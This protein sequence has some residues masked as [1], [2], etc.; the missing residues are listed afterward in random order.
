MS[1]RDKPIAIATM[2][3]GMKSFNAQFIVLDEVGVTKARDGHT[4]HHYLVAD[5]TAAI[6]LSLWDAVGEAVRL[7][8]ILRLNNGYC[9]LHNQFLHLYTAKGGRLIRIGQFSM[10]FTETPNLSL[11][12]WADPVP[13]EQPV[14]P[15]PFFFFDLALVM[16]IH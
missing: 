14:R 1:S 8:D 6:H 11:H 10:L 15:V 5:G 3:P 13:S 4:I 7:G 12:K 9:S 2:K 16:V